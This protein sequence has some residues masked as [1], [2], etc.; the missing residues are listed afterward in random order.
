VML[1][2][3]IAATTHRR[4]VLGFCIGAPW[5]HTQRCYRQAYVYQGARSCTIGSSPFGEQRRESVSNLNYGD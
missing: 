1:I 4:P 2:D 5:E 3:A